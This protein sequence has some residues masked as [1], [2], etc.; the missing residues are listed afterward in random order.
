MQKIAFVTMA[1]LALNTCMLLVFQMKLAPLLWH[2]SNRAMFACGCRCSGVL[3]PAVGQREVDV[4]ITWVDGNDPA[5]L[6]RRAVEAEA[7]EESEVAQDATT[8]NR[9]RDTGSGVAAL[10]HSPPVINPH[11]LLLAPVDLS[12][13]RVGSQGVGGYRR[14]ASSL[15]GGSQLSMDKHG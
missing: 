11:S 8:D 12:K 9:F 7:E 4:V 14:S 1:F 10:C 15:H 3:P 13:R 6:G 2:L 5:W